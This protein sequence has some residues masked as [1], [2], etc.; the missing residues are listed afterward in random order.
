MVLRQSGF[1]TGTKSKELLR[2]S[3]FFETY[4]HSIKNDKASR[5]ESRLQFVMIK[6]ESAMFGSS[7]S[8]NGMWNPAQHLGPQTDTSTTPC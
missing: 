7:I 1:P 5:R 4:P 2:R 3:Y 8:T 6:S